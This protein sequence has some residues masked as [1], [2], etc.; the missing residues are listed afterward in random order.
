MLT[1][2][3]TL[4]R[5]WDQGNLVRDLT[6]HQLQRLGSRVSDT[7]LD[8]RTNRSPIRPTLLNCSSNQDSRASL[9][10]P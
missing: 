1:L 7:H 6:R 3:P 5:P 10:T 8:H 9:C 4:A 2:M